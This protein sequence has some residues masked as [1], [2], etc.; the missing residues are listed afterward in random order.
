[1]RPLA[2]AINPILGSVQAIF[3]GRLAAADLPTR[4]RVEP[5]PAHGSMRAVDD[6]HLT[7]PE[8]MTIGRP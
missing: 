3:A 6:V 4:K 5:F 2:L 7:R 8:L 1:L